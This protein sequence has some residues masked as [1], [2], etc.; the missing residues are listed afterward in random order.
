M[1]NSFHTLVIKIANEQ[2]EIEEIICLHK[3]MNAP[4]VT[5]VSIQHSF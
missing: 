5:Q 1:A 3:C 2:K 4:L